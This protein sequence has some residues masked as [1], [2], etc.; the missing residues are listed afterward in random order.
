MAFRVGVGGRLFGVLVLNG[1]VAFAIGLGAY[2]AFDSL[3]DGITRVTSQQFPAVVAT[4]RLE[5]QHQ[6]IMRSL[7]QLAL[8]TDTFEREAIGQGLSDQL[9]GYDRLLAEISPQGAPQMPRIEH[10][11]A[12]RDEIAKLR[13]AIDRGV[14]LRTAERRALADRDR[15]VRQLADALA[16]G[17]LRADSDPAVQRWL[18]EA[19]RTL[20]L[21]ASVHRVETSFALQRLAA[22]AEEQLAALPAPPPAAAPLVGVMGT[23]VRGEGSVFQHRRAELQAS[24]TLAGLLGRAGQLSLLNTG[25]T[26]SIFVEHTKLAEESRQQV[27]DVSN[28]YT[29]LFFAS[30]VIVLLGTGLTTLYVKR[31]VVARLWA[32]SQ[33]IRERTEGASPAGDAAPHDEIGELAQALRFYVHETEVKSEALRKNE[34]WLRTVLE[35]APVPLVISGRDDGQI[36]FVN[37]MAVALFG[38]RDGGRLLGRPAASLWLEPTSRDHFVR[39]VFTKGAALD[40]ETQLVTES[41]AIWGLLSAISFEFQ[42]EEV[43]L[44]ALVDITRRREAEG[45]LLRTQA[46]LDAVIDNVPSVLYVLDAGSGRVVLWNRAAELAFATRREDIRGRLL[47][48][49]LP[50]ETGRALAGGEAF[51][52][53][54]VFG[55]GGEARVFALQRHPFAWSDEGG[56]HVICVAN[57]VTASRRAREEL[58]HAK[59]RAE[60][61]DAAKT[62]FLATVSHEMRTPL[63]GILGLCRLL[64]TGGLESAER[65]YAES[66][67]RCGHGLL[68]Q[69]ND[70]LDLRKIEDGKLDLDPAPCALTPLLDEVMATVESVANEKGIA[71]TL[72]VA[73]EVPASIVVDDQRLRQILVN[74]AG[75]AVK[76]TERGGVDV[77]ISRTERENGPR[78]VIAVRDSGI[79]V[80]PE[81]RAAIF[82]KLEQADPTIARRFGGSGLGL[83]IVR[84]LLDAMHGDIALDSAVGVGSV[85]TVSIPLVPVEDDRSPAGPGRAAP[86]HAVRSMKLLLVEDDPINREVAVGLLSDAGHR[87]TVAETGARALEL[88]E[89]RDFDAV[90]LDIR[91]PDLDG[92]EVARRIRALRDPARAAVPIVAVTANVFAADRVRYT[93][94]GIDAVIE[95]PIFPERLTHLLFSLTPPGTAGRDSGP[96]LDEAV[97]ERYHRSLGPARFAAIRA[98]LVE[99]AADGL[100]GLGTEP[101]AGR[102]EDV[103]HRL[104][105]AAS[106][107]GLSAVVALL[108]KVEDLARDGQPDAARALAAGAPA[109]FAEALTAMDA[110]CERHVVSDAAGR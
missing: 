91:L 52:E 105:G 97:L 46:F 58:R 63:N 87:I 11:K 17:A 96:L 49:A 5:R 41:G 92:P 88:A 9:A 70:I 14:A 61:A 42:G 24:E 43:M 33:T 29:R 16:D 31:K 74:L 23:L 109:R 2:A 20:F 7:E 90:L 93:Q 107:F 35:A 83:A 73:P 50:P 22:R 62:E 51:A 26:T 36:R 67:M 54:V 6:R 53:E 39:D 106:H 4:A 56:R 34:Q 95:K 25:L 59:E 45:L 84:H 12:Q 68:D 94:A 101:D 65:R 110:W 78:L 99:A 102:I 66:I 82:E 19:E 81:R 72:D 8:S 47:A 55:E 69:V 103:A 21:I 15:D 18:V 64:L 100:P 71:L 98:L 44:T 32:V 13:D 40:V 37:R 48:E 60:R 75:N 80:P 85:F 108:R 76:F 89:R 1:L 104:A 30:I 79:G 28:T 77:R 3:H 86:L 27:I 38:A 57:D 10:L